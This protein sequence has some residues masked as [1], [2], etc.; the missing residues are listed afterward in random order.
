MA[1]SGLLQWAARQS[2]EVENMLTGVERL[3][4]YAALPCEQ[5][6]SSTLTGYKGGAAPHSH[7]FIH[8]HRG[9]LEKGG[10][11]IDME[12]LTTD[13]F[14]PVP[15]IDTR[16]KGIPTTHVATS[17]SVLRGEL[18]VT[19][20]VVSYREDMPPV[21]DGINL[22]V[23]A[24]CKVGVCGR[25]GSG[26]SSLLLALLRL[27]VIQRGDIQID[28]QSI[29]QL[30][31]ESARHLVTCIPQTPDIFSGTLR[32]NLDPF[33]EYT[34]VQLW[35]ALR[36]AHIHEYVMQDPRGLDAIVEEGGKNFSVGQRQLLSL[37]RAILRHSPLV[38]L[39]EATANID[40]ATDRLIQKTVR[41]SPSF[42]NSTVVTI[43]H[44]LRTIADCDLIVV[45]RE[46]R[47]AEVG[48]PH[49]LLD[50][51][52]SLFRALALESNEFEEIKTLA[53][54]KL[55]TNNDR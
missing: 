27:N 36:D 32:F 23:C 20:L 17:P 16:D 15:S 14:I 46:G 37:A 19:D 54:S 1:L 55:I 8:S 39:D 47:A 11:I 51:D 13:G 24:G 25:T 33:G 10:D 40:Y 5:G 44:R 31:L 6:Y 35:Q 48:K 49:E 12:S 30:D 34:D 43:A 2:A 52:Q 3:S 26:K 42:V 50:R 29:L 4:T 18:R 22:H 9:G 41:Q 45:I 38:L 53:M 21:L 28:G 7:S